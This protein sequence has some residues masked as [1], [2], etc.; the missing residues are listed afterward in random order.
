MRMKGHFGHHGHH[1]PHHGHHGH[2]GPHH[3]PHDGHHGPYHGKHFMLNPHHCK[4]KHNMLKRLHKCDH[5]HHAWKMHCGHSRSPTP[6]Q[7]NVR[8]PGMMKHFGRHGKSGFSHF[9]GHCC[10]ERTVHAQPLSHRHGHN[11]GRH[12]EGGRRLSRFM[13][14]AHEGPN[15]CRSSSLPPTIS[16]RE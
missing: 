15:H 14:D 9:R 6:Q 12:H 5:Q 2:H 3:G 16:L 4:P 8:N 1:G 10:E 11:H 7:V 13:S